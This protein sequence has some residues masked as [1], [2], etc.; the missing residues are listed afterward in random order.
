EV[1]P[2]FR[3]HERYIRPMGSYRYALKVL[4][5]YPDDA[6]LGCKA[7]PGEWQVAYHGT[8]F[9]NISGIIREGFKLQY[10]QRTCYGEGIY[11]AP[12]P[13][14]ALNYSTPY[15]AQGRWFKAIVQVR[16]DPLRKQTIKRKNGEVYWL[17]PEESAM[18]SYA[19]CVY[20]VPYAAK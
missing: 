3:G 7:L 5:K 17:V 20:E 8:H 9:E 10:C 19:V 2:V 11:C 13:E 14:I 12:D 4:R 15:N 16:V 6:W 1:P 18:R